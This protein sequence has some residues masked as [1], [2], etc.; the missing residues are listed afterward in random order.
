[1]TGTR[2]GLRYP[3]G[4]RLHKTP[5]PSRV[6][7]PSWRPVGQGKSCASTTN[8]GESAC[9]PWRMSHSAPRFPVFR[10][11]SPVVYRP[12]DARRCETR[13]QLK[14]PCVRCL[15]SK[16]TSREGRERNQPAGL[17]EI[18]VDMND[19][20]GPRMVGGRRAVRGRLGNCLRARQFERG[21]TDSDL[22]FAGAA[23]RSNVH[24]Y[25]SGRRSRGS[26]SFSS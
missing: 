15:C 16:C 1:M 6:L 19:D 12:H 3:I 5:N 22:H 11:D 24:A 25:L 17:A 4:R 23:D 21:L 2:W 10:P 18:G 13:S 14:H 20:I 7:C 26:E 9:V 8:I